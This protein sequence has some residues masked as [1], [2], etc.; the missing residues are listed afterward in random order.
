MVPSIDGGLDVEVTRRLRAVW[1]GRRDAGEFYRLS[2]GRLAVWDPAAGDY[3][4][5]PADPGRIDLVH[6]KSDDE[7]VRIWVW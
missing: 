5:F 3:R 2:A 4:E 6:V 1:Y 7:E